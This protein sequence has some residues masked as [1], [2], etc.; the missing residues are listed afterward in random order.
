MGREKVYDTDVMCWFH[1]ERP[2]IGC[3]ERG[4]Q[5]REPAEPASGERSLREHGLDQKTQNQKDREGRGWHTH[6]SVG[7]QGQEALA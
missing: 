1:L 5:W 7:R 6:W 3:V 2:L 4:K